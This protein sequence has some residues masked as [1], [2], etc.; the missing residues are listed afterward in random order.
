ML[1]WV[2][3]IR[4][5]AFLIVLVPLGYCNRISLTGWFINNGN[6]LLQVLESGKSKIKVLRDLA[7]DESWFIGGRLLA[8]TSL[9]RSGQGNAL[10]HLLEEH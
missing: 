5:N 2:K 4:L 8:I 3:L 10:G 1:I 9:S 7:S 6:L